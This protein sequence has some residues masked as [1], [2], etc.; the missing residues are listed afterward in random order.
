MHASTRIFWANLTPFSLQ[1]L[2][3][4]R[5]NVSETVETVDNNLIKSLTNM[6]NTYFL[7]FVPDPNAEEGV[8][9]CGRPPP[10][11]SAHDSIQVYTK[12]RT[13]SPTCYN[14]FLPHRSRSATRR[15][16]SPSSSSRSSGA[17][18]FL[19]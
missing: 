4:T 8:E 2:E 5:F 16:S 11:L 17:R 1:L 12:F 10:S 19:L 15:R 7:N 14:L 13:I 9:V 18:R 6:L 3:H